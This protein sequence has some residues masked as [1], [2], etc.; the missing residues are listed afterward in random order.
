MEASTHNRLLQLLQDF[1]QA[2]DRYVESTGGHYGTHRTDKNG[3]TLIMK[4][5]RA[6]TLPSPRDLSR[7]LQLS[8]PATT[9]MLDR[10]DRLGYITRRRSEQDRRSVHIALTDKAMTGA[11]EMFRPLG[12]MMTDLISS[13]DEQQI[14]LLS[15]FMSRAVAGVDAARLEVVAQNK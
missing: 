10:L 9:A 6:G 14:E 7:E 3:L 11:R 5:Q 4:Y 15:D 2:S 1:G 8:S 12:A 13:Y